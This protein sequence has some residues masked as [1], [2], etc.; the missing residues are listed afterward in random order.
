M[1]QCRKLAEHSNLFASLVA[2]RS[3]LSR[4][5][6]AMIA[7]ASDLSIY[8]SCNRHW[9]KIANLSNAFLHSVAPCVE[10]IIVIRFTGLNK[11]SL[12]SLSHIRPSLARF[13]PDLVVKPI[14]RATTD[15][16]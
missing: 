15:E 14:K 4:G 13:I 1:G 12:D 7:S 10:R 9:F 3:F 2:F 11:P 6:Y 8:P 5:G 16:E